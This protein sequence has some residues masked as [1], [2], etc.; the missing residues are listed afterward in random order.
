M[1]FNNKALLKILALQNVKELKEALKKPL[2]VNREQGNAMSILSTVNS[3]YSDGILA[4]PHTF[5]R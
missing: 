5:K 3:R 1:V 4:Q 2:F